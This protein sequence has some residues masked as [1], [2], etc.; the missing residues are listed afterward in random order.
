[1]AKRINQ[2]LPE[3]QALNERKLTAAAENP[4]RYLEKH[5]HEIKSRADQE[6]A[7]FAMLRLLRKRPR[8]GLCLL[9]EDTR[10]DSAMRSMRILWSNVA[11]QAA[12]KLNPRALS[13]FE[14]AASAS[15]PA[16]LSDA[17]L[18]WKTRAALRAGD[19]EL[20]SETIEAMSPRNNRR[21]YGVTGRRGL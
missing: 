13:W 2:Y 5:R 20:V 8:S 17:Q 21:E 18:G 4:L 3:D 11:D 1:M 16:V 10:D 19:W 9:A 7:L 12:R 15:S 14:E 6:I